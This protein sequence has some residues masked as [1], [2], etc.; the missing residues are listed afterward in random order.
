MKYKNI[1]FDFGGTLVNLEPSKDDVFFNVLERNNIIIN[2]DKILKAFF[3]NNI[4]QSAI[5]LKNE[6]DKKIFLIEYNK[7]ILNSLKI[8]SNI[9]LLAIE[10]N[11]EFKKTHWRIS[12][13]TIKVLEELRKSGFRLAILSNW[14]NN[15]RDICDNL[16]ISNFFELILASTDVNIEKPSPEFFK[17]ILSRLKMNPNE[18]IYVGDDYEQDVVSAESVDIKPLLIDKYGF[19]SNKNCDKIRNLKSIFLFVNE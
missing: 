12:L 6:E 13:E 18:T 10:I 1:I 11:N 3:N 16:G 2:K 9:D 5:I 15:L 8:K 17:I 4:R 19:Y 7:S 14:E